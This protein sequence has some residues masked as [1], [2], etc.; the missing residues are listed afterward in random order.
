MG[1]PISLFSRRFGHLDSVWNRGAGS[2]GIRTLEL[3][4][5]RCNKSIMRSEDRND[6]KTAVK[7]VKK[8]KHFKVCLSISARFRA[9]NLDFEPHFA[10]LTNQAYWSP[11]L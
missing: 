8:F 11:F 1:R 7:Y 4:W 9:S 3:Q 10:C 2:R 5:H 6:R